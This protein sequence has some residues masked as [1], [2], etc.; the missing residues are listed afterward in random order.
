MTDYVL[1]RAVLTVEALA[2]LW[3]AR[4]AWAEAAHLRLA[5]RAIGPLI[6]C[7]AAILIAY[8]LLR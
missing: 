8:G 1:A 6:G 3:L 7:I 5:L 4:I 2:C